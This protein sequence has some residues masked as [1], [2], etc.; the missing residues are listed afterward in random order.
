MEKVYYGVNSI[1]AV[2]RS[3]GKRFFLSTKYPAKDFDITFGEALVKFALMLNKRKE[4]E[5]VNV[6]TNES[7]Y[8]CRDCGNEFSTGMKHISSFNERQDKDS[9]AASKLKVENPKTPQRFPPVVKKN[10]PLGEKMKGFLRNSNSCEIAEN[11]VVSTLTG[12]L[13]N[14]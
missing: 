10:T 14:S 5:P 13:E 12:E 7:R 3:K 11:K 1:C 8:L 9:Y 2:E 6:L 4:I